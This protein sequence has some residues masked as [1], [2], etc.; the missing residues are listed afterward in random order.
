MNSD[1][2]G[3]GIYIYYHSNPII[4]QNL[5]TQPTRFINTSQTLIDKIFTNTFD[6]DCE[7][8]NILIEF[9][10]HLTQFVSVTNNNNYTKNK[11]VYKLDHL[12]FDENLFL[13]DLSIQAFLQTEAQ[14]SIFWSFME[15]WIMC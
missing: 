4:E 7:S 14:H 5:I 11:P 12:K 3:G 2:G 8:G 15:L 13:E 6:R 1:L 10:D 9:A